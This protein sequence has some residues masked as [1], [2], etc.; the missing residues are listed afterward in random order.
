MQINSHLG[1]LCLI[2]SVSRNQLLMNTAVNRTME[3]A[4]TLPVAA[5]ATK[6]APIKQQDD[7]LK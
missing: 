6:P 4:S 1:I 2:L 3:I 5:S 7:A